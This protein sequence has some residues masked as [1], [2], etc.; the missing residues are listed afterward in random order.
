MGGGPPPALLHGFPET[1]PMWRDV[2]PLLATDF[3]VVCPDLRG[4]GASGCPPSDEQHAPYSKR[5]M[6]QDVRRVMA[7]LGFDRFAVAGHDRGGRWPTG[8]H[9]ITRMPPRPSPCPT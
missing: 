7:K 2:A 4:Y 9:S 1:H 3:T 6:A 5:A 8:W